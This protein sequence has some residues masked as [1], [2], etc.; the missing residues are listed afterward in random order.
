MGCVVS[1]YNLMIHSHVRFT[2]AIGLVAISGWMAVLVSIATAYEFLEKRE[3]TL[4]IP[5][6]PAVHTTCVVSG[7]M[8]NGSIDVGI[9]VPDGKKYSLFGYLDKVDG[10]VLNNKKA[11]QTSERVG[12]FPICV[13]TNDGA[14]ELCLSHKV[15]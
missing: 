7:G 8:S 13:M 9:K 3:C 6:R 14:F 5:T 10:W 2:T 4:Q 15:E 1:G 12:E 11:K